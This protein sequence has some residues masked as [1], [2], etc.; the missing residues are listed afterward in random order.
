MRLAHF[1]DLH[2]RDSI[3]G[4]APVGRRRSREILPLFAEALRT[5]KDHRVDM[6]AVTGDLLDVPHFLIDRVPRGFVMPGAESWRARVR[7]DYRALRK[8]LQETGIPYVVLPGNHDLPEV[9]FEVFPKEQ[10]ADKCAGFRIVTFDDYEHDSNIPRRFVPS[11]TLFEEA[12][13][14]PDRAPQIHLQHYLL[15]PLNEAHDYPYHY[16]EH[17]FLRGR[18]EGAG[19]VSLCLSGHYHRGTDIILSNSTAYA[20]TPAFCDAPHHWRIYEVEAGGVRFQEFA[21]QSERGTRLSTVFLD[22]DGVINDLASYAAGPEEMRLIPGSAAAIRK[23]NER[24]IKT[25][26]VTSQSAIGQGY[27]PEAVV[28]M[29]HER[30]HDLLAREGACVDAVYYTKG[31]GPD[32]VIPEWAD[33]PVRKATLVQKA[34]E[35]LGLELCG[36]W[37]VGDR[38]SDMRAAEESGVRRILVRTGDGER[39]LK[40]AQAGDDFLVAGNLEEAVERILEAGFHA[41]TGS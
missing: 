12:L 28:H 22:R 1:T 14:E 15:H 35:E 9:F 18:I 40:S 34:A 17:E 29:V 16:L 38:L 27:V 5:L 4:S 23:L 24:G 6:I 2:F 21:A 36:A 13:R 19:M 37:L 10:R 41:P 20:T 33:L 30:M 32:S 7:S 3:P 25:V 26:V 11:R 8:L 31:A 39:A